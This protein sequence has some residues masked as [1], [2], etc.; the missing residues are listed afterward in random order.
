MTDDLS[1]AI[2]ED[3][4]EEVD[5]NVEIEEVAP[6]TGSVNKRT[7]L[8]FLSGGSLLLS[9]FNNSS[10]LGAEREK[11]L[12]HGFGYS[13]ELSCS[14]NFHKYLHLSVGINYSLYAQLIQ[15]DG[16]FVVNRDGTYVGPEIDP[17]FASEDFLLII[18]ERNL[19]IY[20]KRSF[21]DVPISLSFQKDIGRLV[22]EPTL[23]IAFN[24]Y[25][26]HSGNTINNNLI[27]EDLNLLSYDIGPQFGLGLGLEYR[28]TESWNLA[29]RVSMSRRRIFDGIIDEI[30]HLPQLSVGVR[31]GLGLN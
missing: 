12:S 5:E 10:A 15:W 22:V 31:Y 18:Q 6:N 9:N 17:N 25:N 14:F 26:T 27:P 3:N 28:L 11:S 21:L 13:G 20:N 23:S 4:N 8:I 30:I 1:S 19:A 7:S 24:I 16:Q 2:T 29:S